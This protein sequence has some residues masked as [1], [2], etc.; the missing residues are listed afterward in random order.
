M[1]QG[2]IRIPTPASPSFS[3]ECFPPKT[4]KQEQTLAESCVELAKLG[5]EYFSVTFGAGGST[6]VGTARTVRAIR[7][8][9][10]IEV[11]PHISCIG[12]EP[13]DVLALIR[14]YR[15]EGVRRIVAL[16]G[17][18]PSGTGAPGKL[19][20]ASDL[21]AFI[22][23]HTGDW[24]HIEVGCYPEFHPQAPDADADLRNFRRKVKAGANV[25]IT[26]Y[27]FNPD[28]YFRFIDEIRRMGIEIPVV[29]GVMPLTNYKQIA[30]FS[31][32]CGAEI[33][34]WIRKRLEAYDEREDMESLRAFGVEVITDLC[35]KLLEGGA[36]GL[37]F[38]TL[39][40]AWAT[41]RIW[42]N[43]G[44]PKGSERKA[45]AAS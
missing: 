37:H 19:R 26:Q 35:A 42:E 6:R 32:A 12:A 18:I 7:E 33:P 15:D 9:T 11:A 21:V 25:A 20:Y 14:R 3:F 43:L 2:T 41:T 34:R 13:E 17:D 39:N 24:F 1:S 45:D 30:R 10:G 44:L 28:A 22:R 40:K 29:P 4:E 27:F 16:R 31:D 38:Y 5:P 8:R 23:E 36:P